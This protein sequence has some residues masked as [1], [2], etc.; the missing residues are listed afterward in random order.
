MKLDLSALPTAAF[1]AFGALV[2]LQLTLTVVGLVVL[3]RTPRE[4]LV[5]E[6]KWPWVLIIVL[7][8]VVGSIVFLAAARRPAPAADESTAEPGDDGVARVVRNLYGTDRP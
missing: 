2:V 1:I 8:N 5:F 3:V 6:R 7:V 4:R